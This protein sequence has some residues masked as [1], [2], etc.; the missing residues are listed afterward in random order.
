MFCEIEGSSVIVRLFLI[1]V[2]VTGKLCW[3]NKWSVRQKERWGVLLF[4]LFLVSEC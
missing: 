4:K 3:Y 1:S 2:T